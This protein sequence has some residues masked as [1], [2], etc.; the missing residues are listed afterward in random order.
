MAEAPKPNA[1]LIKQLKAVLA[2][3]EAGTVTNG[4]VVATGATVYH[5]TFSVPKPE[6]MA[7]MIGE[8]DMFKVEMGL[9]VMGGRT[10]QDQRRNALMGGHRQ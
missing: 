1:D 6:D 3:A 10:Q 5:R 8:L 7:L 2:M 4:V 9:I